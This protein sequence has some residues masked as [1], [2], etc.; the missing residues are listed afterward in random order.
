M[1]DQLVIRAIV[2]D[3]YTALAEFNSSFPDD[4]LSK[5]DWLKR[6]NYWWDENPAYITDWPSGFV[7]IAEDR[8]Q[9]FVGSFPTFFNAE[10]TK[11][12]AFNGTTW[13]VHKSYRKWS[14][15]LWAQN[16]TASSGMLCFNTTAT[17]DVIRLILKF[18]YKRYPWGAEKVS[19]QLIRPFDALKCFL[20]SQY[21]CLSYPAGILIQARDAVSTLLFNHSF[22]VRFSGIKESEIDDLWERTKSIYPYTNHRSS[23]VVKWYSAKRLLVGIYH[24]ETLAAYAIFSE[25]RHESYKFNELVLVD[26]W[27]DPLFGLKGLLQALIHGVKTYALQHN[28][29][30]VK[31]HHF[32]SM[33]TSILMKLPLLSRNYIPGGY[34][35][36]DNLNLTQTNSYFTLLQ[37]DFDA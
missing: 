2:K 7:I 3:D 34:I 6:F 1:T 31:Y 21:C 24:D 17:E 10:G 13:R 23:S 11:I 15:D 32:S 27:Y 26:F 5:E 14:I 19:Y 12:R 9:G 18:G 36:T 30:M 4:R 25:F 28:I 37:G 29:V 16:R 35:K 22:Q 33:M 20:P 8:I